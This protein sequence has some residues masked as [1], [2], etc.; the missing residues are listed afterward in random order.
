MQQI[1]TAIVEGNLR[2][3]IPKD[4]PK[5]ISAIIEQCWQKNKS[6]RPT[7]LVRPP[8]PLPDSCFA[9]CTTACAWVGFA[10]LPPLLAARCGACTGA[11][12]SSSIFLPHALH[13]CSFPFSN[14]FM[15]LSDLTASS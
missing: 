1:K 5:F 4:T 10:S 8:S 3:T 9:P 7:L 2:P 11:G 14:N 13:P 12:V 6:Q 15:F